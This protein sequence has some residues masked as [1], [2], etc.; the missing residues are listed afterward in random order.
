MYFVLKFCT[1][2]HF[3]HYDEYTS[4]VTKKNIYT[5][6]FSAFQK[7][8]IGERPN[9]LELL[10]LLSSLFFETCEGFLR[11]FPG[12]AGM[13]LRR[14]YYKLR[15]NSLGT[16]VLIDTGVFLIGP[17]NISIGNYTW[18]DTNVRLESMLGKITIGSRVHIA[19]N[20]II[21]ARESVVIGDFAGIA[22]GAKVYASSVVPLP[23]LHMSGPMV[24]EEHKGFKSKQ[25]TLGKDSLVGANAVLLPGAN[26]GEGS[27]VGAL[28]LL[29]KTIPDWEIW[30]GCPA[31][32]VGDRPDTAF[33][34]GL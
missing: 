5:R 12:T 7:Y 11:Y 9:F 25:I 6:Q 10:T 1:I 32:K 23:G 33:S 29:S 3:V 4:G 19:P 30:S 27:I 34:F 16:N 15:L 22:A 28:S 24:P 14:G 18:I 17:K 2:G 13:L 26:L 20:V 21:G 8:L 31:Q